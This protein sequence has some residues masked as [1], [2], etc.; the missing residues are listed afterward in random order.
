MNRHLLVGLAVVTASA[1][2]L[3]LPA[4]AGKPK[5]VKGTYAVTLAP[6]VV[7]NVLAQQSIHSCDP[8]I[9]QGSDKHPFLAPAA[10]T[11]TVTLDSADP[12]PAAAPL[13][14]DWDLYVMDAQG[15]VG[16][17]NSGFAHEEVVVSFK[18]KDPLTFIV[19]NINGELN[20]TVTYTF[21]YK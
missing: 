1:S 14:A 7:P 5:P 11:L 15:E 3:S 16:S 13:H 12:T 8:Y 10:G 9:A 6:D 2:A 18:K 4:A 17:S 19:C 21:T 20:A